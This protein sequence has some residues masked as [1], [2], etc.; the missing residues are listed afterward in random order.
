MSEELKPTEHLRVVSGNPSAEELAVVV[1]VLQAA[2]SA[3]AASAAA[4]ESKRLANWH[5]NPGVMRGQVI[6][7]HGQWVASVRRGLH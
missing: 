3:S 7:G 1:A 5:R 6:P 4:T 2:A